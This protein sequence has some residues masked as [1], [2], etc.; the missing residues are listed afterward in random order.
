[1]VYYNPHLIG[2]Y[3]PQYNPNQPGVLFSL[4]IPQTVYCWGS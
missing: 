4:L 2:E 1:M 3:T